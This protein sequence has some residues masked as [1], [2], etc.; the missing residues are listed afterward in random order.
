M[1]ISDLPEGLISLILSNLDGKSIFVFLYMAVYESWPWEEVQIPHLDFTDTEVT[2]R[3]LRL[4]LRGHIVIK[5]Q[6]ISLA[7]CT[8]L[9]Y[10]G[11]RDLHPGITSLDISGFAVNDRVIKSITCFPNI[12]QLN[13]ANCDK[14]SDQNLTIIKS[15]LPHLKQLNLFGCNRVTSKKVMELST[16]PTTMQ[17]DLYNLRVLPL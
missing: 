11:L 6:T 8:K 4:I 17:I 5:Y 15:S 12:R 13:L 1:N 14:L 7:N 16:D 9:T 10:K 3:A 2:N